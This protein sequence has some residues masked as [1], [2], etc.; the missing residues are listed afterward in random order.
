M[1][2]I[3]PEHGCHDFFGYSDHQPFDSAKIGRIDPETG[4]LEPLAE[5]TARQ[6]PQ[7]SS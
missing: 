2:I 6:F 1:R 3:P 7:K 5:T 4:R